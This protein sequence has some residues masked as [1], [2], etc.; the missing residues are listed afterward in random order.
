MALHGFGQILGTVQGDRAQVLGEEV[1]EEG[2]GEAANERGEAAGG[3]GLQVGAA[4]GE[5]LPG[6]A[7]GVEPGAELDE[8][9]AV[10]AGRTRTLLHDASHQVEEGSVRMDEDVAAG[11]GLGAGAAQGAVQEAEAEPLRGGA[12]GRG[13][14]VPDG[15]GASGAFDERVAHVGIAHV[16][17]NCK[18]RT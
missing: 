5:G 13:H 12:P 8:A 4:D 16:G 2:P 10:L 9:E 18:M 1:V 14:L 15:G 17:I 6:P 11:V 7:A 3:L